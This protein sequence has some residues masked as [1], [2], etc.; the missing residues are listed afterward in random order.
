MH[1]DA[2]AILEAPAQ[3]EIR[4]KGSRFLALALP[5][6]DEAGAEALRARLEGDHRDA[7]HLCWGLRLGAPDVALE[8]HSDAGEPAGSAGAPIARAIASSGLSDLLV[9]VVR[10]FGGTKLGVGGL[11]RAYGEAAALCLRSASAAERIRCRRLAGSLPFEMEGDLRTLLA[12]H[13]GRLLSIGYGA[14]G[15]EVRLETP[16]S[17]VDSLKQNVRDLG[18]GR[19]TLQESDESL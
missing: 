17:S 7:T 15:I 11:I 14:D 2:Y 4:V 12:R 3:A 18:R 19:F 8:R 10:W 9:V 1:P 16:A 5:A 6:V 13:G